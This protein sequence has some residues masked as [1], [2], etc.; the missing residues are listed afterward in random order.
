M[1]KSRLTVLLLCLAGTVLATPLTFT[2]EDPFNLPGSSDVIGDKLKFDIKQAMVTFDSGTIALEIQM[3][4]A[5]AGLNPFTFDGLNLGIG[6]VLFEVDGVAR[7]GLALHNHGTGSHVVQA[8]HLYQINDPLKGVQTAEQVLEDPS[9]WIYRPD[10][11]VWLNNRKSYLTDLATGTITVE[12]LGNNGHDGAKY[13]ILA[14]FAAPTA[15]TPGGAGGELALHFAAATCGN[16]VLNGALP[17]GAVPEP[18]SMA[19]LSG[20]LALLGFGSRRLRK[21]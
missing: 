12:N 21:Q 8:G 17:A 1:I 2:I 3:N 11:L 6:D 18:G 9:G 13:A 10:E 5:N 14:Q 15:L 7:F 19:L 4:Y 20:G 16:D